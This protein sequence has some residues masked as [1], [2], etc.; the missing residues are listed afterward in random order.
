M[1]NGMT[2]ELQCK[3]TL[4]CARNDAPYILMIIHRE[5]C[6]HGLICLIG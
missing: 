4:K 2:V 6:S 1:V 3:S 5:P